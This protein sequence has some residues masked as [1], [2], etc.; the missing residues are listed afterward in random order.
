[1][2]DDP[3]PTTNHTV[4]QAISTWLSCDR[5][6]RTKGLIDQQPDGKGNISVQL[7]GLFYQHIGY[8]W[9]EAIKRNDEGSWNVTTITWHAVSRKNG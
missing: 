7:T 6:W 5:K 9:M 4:I 1:M 2:L 3:I 8:R